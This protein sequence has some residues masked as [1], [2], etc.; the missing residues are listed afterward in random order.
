VVMS[1]TDWKMTETKLEFSTPLWDAPPKRDIAVGNGDKITLGDTSVALYL[2][3]GHTLGTLSPVFDVRSGGQTHRVLLWGGT[4]FNFGKDLD[5][6]DSYVGSTQNM[7]ALAEQQRVD[8]LLSNHPNYDNSLL[9]LD[10]LR[11]QNGGQA[12]PFVMGTP[13]VVRALNVMGE[14]AQATHDRF[15]LPQ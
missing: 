1:A 15:A 9:K 12:N 8:V 4:A 5:R 10:Q 11:A 7:R 14:C 2:T 6:L 13:T 3:P